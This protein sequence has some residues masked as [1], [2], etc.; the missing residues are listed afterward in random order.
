[1]PASSCRSERGRWRARALAAALL[2]AGAL[3]VPAWALERAHAAGRTGAPPVVTGWDFTLPTL[4]GSRF[5]RLRDA[6]GPVLVNFWGTDCPPCVAEMPLLLDFA[7]AHPQWTV[8]LVGTD[9]PAAAREFAALKL[10]APLPDNVHL[11]RGAAQARALLN[12]AGNRQ[13]ALPYSVALY[14]AAPLAGDV[15]AGMLD[16]WRLQ[17]W[18]ASCREGAR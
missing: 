8:L 5:V 16:A 6:A 3:A 11:L 15:H 12:E 1:M 13:G 10:P 7:R 9:P 17:R 4:H 2:L 18:A 14:G